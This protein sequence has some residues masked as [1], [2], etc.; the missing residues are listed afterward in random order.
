[1]PKRRS[2]QRPAPRAIGRGPLDFARA[3]PPPDLVAALAPY[4]KT[5]TKGT[6]NGYA[7]LDD[8]GKV[9]ET[10][11]PG[12]TMVAKSSDESRQ[13]TVSLAN[14]GALVLAVDAT[15]RYLIRGVV[16]FSTTAAAG[17]RFAHTGPGDTARITIQNRPLAG[18]LDVLTPA[19]VD[20]ALGLVDVLTG[21]GAD[22][23]LAFDG[24]LETGAS[25]GTY[26]LQWAQAVSTAVNTTV[27]RGSYLEHRKL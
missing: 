21:T 2:P 14:D 15:S 1:M 20:K 17:I 11:L 24:I 12:W 9:P 6:P 13:S 19:P 8:K 27:L 7:S 16:F 3:L 26:A 25:A 22:G 10:L 18:G 5:D 23:V 4:Q